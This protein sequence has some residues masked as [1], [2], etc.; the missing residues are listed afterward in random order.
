MKGEG[1]ELDGNAGRWRL[2]WQE[3]LARLSST[4]SAVI[5][6]LVAITRSQVKNPGKKVQLMVMSTSDYI[7]GECFKLDEGTRCHPR[8]VSRM[9]CAAHQETR[10]LLHRE[11]RIPSGGGGER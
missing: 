4:Q 1:V 2:R 7:R 9:L 10:T 3:G 6:Y 11:A 8:K 5:L